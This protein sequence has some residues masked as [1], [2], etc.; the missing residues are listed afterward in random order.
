MCLEGERYQVIRSVYCERLDDGFWAEPLN[1]ISNL[2]FV[3]AALVAAWVW[4]RWARSDR[5]TGGLII[6]TCLIGIGSF[7][8]HTMPNGVTVLMDIVPIQIFIVGYFGL[9][10]RRYLEMSASATL[11]GITVFLAFSLATQ[12]LA[13]SGF[14][15]GGAGYLPALAA[16]L[17][18]GLALVLRGRQAFQANLKDVSSDLHPAQATSRMGYALLAGGAIFSISLAARTLDMPLCPQIPVGLHFVWHGLNGAL[19]CL[20]L[21][22]AIRTH[23]GEKC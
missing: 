1:A 11:I 4:R 7:L 6:V 21:I 22:A 15:R 14:L 18:L 20:L 19:L 9:M 3:M 10:L 16:L 13:P 5:A 23:P 17:G 12:A 8:F 2:S